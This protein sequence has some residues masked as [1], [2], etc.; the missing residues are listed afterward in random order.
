M[1][2]TCTSRNLIVE[3]PPGSGLAQQGEAPPILSQARQR[4]SQREAD[5]EGQHPGVAG[6]G[7]VPE[8]LRAWSK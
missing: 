5:L 7:Q 8:G 4:A 1:A 3:R 6:L 2:S